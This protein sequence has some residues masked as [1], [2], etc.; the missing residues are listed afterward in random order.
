L[1]EPRDAPTAPSGEPDVTD[2]GC[3]RKSYF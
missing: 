1:K 3:V 2:A